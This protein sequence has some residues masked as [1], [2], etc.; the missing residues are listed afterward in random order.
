[1]ACFADEQNLAGIL[2]YSRSQDTIS[3]TLTYIQEI[4]DRTEVMIPVVIA[5]RP[6]RKICWHHTDWSKAAVAN[7]EWWARIAAVRRRVNSSAV[8][9]CASLVRVCKTVAGLGH[10]NT[11]TCS[12][13][14]DQAFAH[15]CRKSCYRQ[16]PTIKSAIWQNSG[17]SCPVIFS[18]GGKICVGIT[19]FNF[20]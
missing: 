2:W 5:P 10:N 3:N 18:L 19:D 14:S 13:C 11:Y 17:Q 12:I 4:C 15:I 9:F 1:M 8:S 6:L 7:M 20:S 16:L